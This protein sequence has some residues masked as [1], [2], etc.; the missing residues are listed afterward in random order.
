M[1]QAVVNFMLTQLK[2]D[3]FPMQADDFVLCSDGN[4]NCEYRT[5]Q[6]KIRYVELNQSLGEIAKDKVLIFRHSTDIR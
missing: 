4:I 3:I 1:N 2:A 5:M 6:E